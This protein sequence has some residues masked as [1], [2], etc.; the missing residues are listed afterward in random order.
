MN[1]EL[2]EKLWNASADQHNQWSELGL[3]EIVYFAQKVEREAC[4]KLCETMGPVLCESYGDGAECIATADACAEA[5]RV[6]AI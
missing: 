4:S 2:L 5:I 3:D 1:I 6:I